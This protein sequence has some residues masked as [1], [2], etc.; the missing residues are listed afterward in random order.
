M[1]IKLKLLNLYGKTRSIVYDGLTQKKCK[2]SLG[3]LMLRRA[4]LT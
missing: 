1:N 3:D 4:D 2:V